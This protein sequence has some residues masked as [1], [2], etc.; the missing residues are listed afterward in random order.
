MPS[1]I[2]RSLPVVVNQPIIDSTIVISPM[3]KQ[4]VLLTLAEETDLANRSRSSADLQSSPVSY[5]R[6]GLALEQG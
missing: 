2:V 5:A 4:P 1:L 6:S 3:G